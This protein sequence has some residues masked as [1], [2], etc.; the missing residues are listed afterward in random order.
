MGPHWGVG[1][2]YPGV[3]SP[4][5]EMQ[6]PLMWGPLRAVYTV[7]P[8]SSIKMQLPLGWGTVEGDLLRNP[9]TQH[10]DTATSGVAWGRLQLR[11]A[12]RGV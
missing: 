8:S 1:S 6:P 2:A 11:G 3:P 12:A 4:S 10:R 5:S 9:L 7:M